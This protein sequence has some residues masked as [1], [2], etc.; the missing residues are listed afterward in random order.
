VG[1]EGHDG[2]GGD[3]VGFFLKV[4]QG[5][6]IAGGIVAE[7]HAPRGGGIGPG[8]QTAATPAKRLEI[9]QFGA[10]GGGVHRAFLRV[11]P[12]DDAP[13]G[14]GILWPGY[15]NSLW[16]LRRFLPVPARKHQ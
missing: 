10:L 1:G 9:G 12:P 6:G 3:R 15:T 13:R 16:Q 5:V 11:R 7:E 4:T 8:R 2:Q 14:R